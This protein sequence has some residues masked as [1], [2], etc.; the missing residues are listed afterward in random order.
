MRIAHVS[1]CYLPQLGG[2]EMHVHDLA[3]QQR[4]AGHEVHVVTATRP[5]AGDPPD[6]PWVRRVACDVPTPGVRTY[7]ASRGLA[8]LLDSGDYDVVHVH[9]SVISPFALSGAYHAATSGLPT[10]VTVHSLWSGLGVLP[11]VAESL[12]QMSRWP[13]VWSAVS[14]T[15]GAPVR[16]ALGDA[17]T[18]AV[19]PNG[20]DPEDWTV[21]AVEP[22][23]GQVTVV[24]VMRLASR[25]RPIPLMRMLRQ[26]RRA[27]PADLALRAVVIGDGPQRSAVERYV[28]WHRMHE[29]VSL[30]GRLDRRSIRD[31]FGTSDLY[32]APADLESFGIAAL[33]ARCAGLPVVASGHGGVAEF[34]SHGTD[35]FLASSDA[36][37]VDAML[38]LIL[39]PG[40]RRSMACHNRAV[41]PGVTWQEVLRRCE[42][43]YAQA[44][45]VALAPR[46]VRPASSHS[47]LLT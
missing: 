17:T 39:Q 13:V 6:P 11:T 37:M 5:A 27:L 23:L 31:V 43:L 2:I 45:A 21:P 41:V 22:V 35:G 33:E 42:Q 34:I 28:R 9:A 25:K 3:V 38:E 8:R 12:L 30:P 15:A 1:D 29:C 26:V 46:S 4:R 16:R 20:I 36:A 40:V 24:T 47:G 18:V 14:E 10:L 19:L 32:V 44:G 7:A